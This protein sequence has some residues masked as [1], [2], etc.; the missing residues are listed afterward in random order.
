MILSDFH[1]SQIGYRLQKCKQKIFKKFEFG[2]PVSEILVFKIF[3][4]RGTHA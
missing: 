2:W 1:N 3:V 4:R